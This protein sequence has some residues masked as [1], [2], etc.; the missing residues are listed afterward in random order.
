MTNAAKMQSKSTFATFFGGGDRRTSFLSPSSSNEAMNDVE[1]EYGPPL[2][3][4]VRTIDGS[5]NYDDVKRELIKSVMNRIRERLE[6]LPIQT[7]D[8]VVQFIAQF[9]PAT[10]SAA[11]L[12]AKRA[13]SKRLGSVGLKLTDPDT[14]MAVI[15]ELY[16][17]VRDE[18]TSLLW[19]DR[20]VEKESV[21][22]EITNREKETLEE[23]VEDE[24]SL[25]VE[26]VE[27]VVTT[28]IF[29]L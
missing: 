5:V 26:R 13:P 17:K 29:D 28:E 27:S 4:N 6:G 14:S 11:A 21:D 7:I 23:E 3:V 2:E 1:Y 8:R 25:A 16:I 15:Q 10:P 18:V 20:M 12:L 19:N 24:A 9:Y 22:E